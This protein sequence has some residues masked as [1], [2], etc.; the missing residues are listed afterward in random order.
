LIHLWEQT[1][2]EKTLTPQPVPGRLFS[3][4]YM[5]NLL[6]DGNNYISLRRKCNKYYNIFTESPFGLYFESV[7]KS[8]ILKQLPFFDKNR[9]G[10]IFARSFL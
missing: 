9:F 10:M 1:N 4:S 3:V 8:D 2:E 6:F 7:S 5:L